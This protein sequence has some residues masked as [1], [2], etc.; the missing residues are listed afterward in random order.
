[1]QRSDL[2]TLLRTYIHNTDTAG[3]DNFSDAS[4]NSLL[5]EAVG[6]VQSELEDLD[7]HLFDT[8]SDTSM[9]AVD[10]AINL[11]ADF[12]KLI[13][14]RRVDNGYNTRFRIIDRREVGAPTRDPL[15]M[16]SNYRAYLTAT[17]IKYVSALNEAHTARLVYSADL[18]NLTL[19]SQSWPIPRAAEQA[20]VFKAAILATK[21]DGMSSNQWEDE[22]AE[23]I[24]KVQQLKSR[25]SS[26]PKYVR[27]P[28]G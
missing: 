9:A 8:E 15:D 25:D 12:R 13:E 22:Y 3:S 21:S 10:V 4:L 24:R 23:A 6:I 16:N 26:G 20:V 2:R 5:Y 7:V 1:M 19:D 27:M 11:P 28:Y 17:Q 14:L 18:A